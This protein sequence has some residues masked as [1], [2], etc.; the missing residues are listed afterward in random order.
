MFHCHK[1]TL[2]VLLL[3]SIKV[4]WLPYLPPDLTYTNSV[5]LCDF[6]GS[7]IKQRFFPY[8][9]IT[10]RDGVFTARYDMNVEM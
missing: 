10:N 7:Q 3:R 4:M 2:T 6:Y 5:Y 8:T 9:A 1:Y